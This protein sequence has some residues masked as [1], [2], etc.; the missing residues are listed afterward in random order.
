MSATQ[1]SKPGQK[2]GDVKFTR[3]QKDIGL[4]L[5]QR[6]DTYVSTLV[7]YYGT[8]EWPG[9]DK[10]QDN[11]S[12]TQIAEMLYRETKSEVISLFSEQRA[13]QRF[14]PYIAMHEF[15]ALLFSDAEILANKLKI[16]ASIVEAVL[17][18]CGF[19]EAINNSLQ[20]APSKRLV[21]T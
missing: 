2:G 16:S 9:L 5:K 15:E 19:P 10:I 13:E 6:S 12:P 4:H 1:V 8:N 3:V 20:T 17:F 7:D 14:I 21:R 11:A 18:E